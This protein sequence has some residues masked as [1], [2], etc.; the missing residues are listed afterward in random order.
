MKTF[1]DSKSF[2]SVNKFVFF[3]LNENRPRRLFSSVKYCLVSIVGFYLM[4]R[5][6]HICS[7]EFFSIYKLLPLVLIYGVSR[8]YSLVRLILVLGVV[9]ESSCS[10]K[11]LSK[12][13]FTSCQVEFLNS[14]TSV[15]LSSTYGYFPIFFT[16]LRLYW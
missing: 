8:V 1:P 11:S 4:N 16:T 15:G 14:S 13:Y 12:D 3:V 10:V 7:S 6:A 2:F 5:L 9:I